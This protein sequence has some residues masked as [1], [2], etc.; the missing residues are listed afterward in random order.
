MPREA[1]VLPGSSRGDRAGAWSPRAGRLL[2]GARPAGGVGPET[3]G[4]SSPADGSCCRPGPAD[5][6][7]PRASRASPRCSQALQASRCVLGG[8][9]ASSWSP[10]QTS[11][12]RRHPPR[13][14]APHP[15]LPEGTGLAA[16]HPLALRVPQDASLVEAELH[17]GPAPGPPAAPSEVCARVRPA[18]RSLR[19]QALVVSG[20]GGVSPPCWGEGVLGT[21]ASACLEQTGCARGAAWGWGAGLTDAGQS[22]LLAG[23][24]V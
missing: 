11:S 13:T 23:A 21:P 12:R 9:A 3:P 19:G 4:L 8:R 22:A 16:E 14:Q 17:P 18:A 1:G 20:S 15:R 10:T 7:S 6:A 24:A 5:L 2:R